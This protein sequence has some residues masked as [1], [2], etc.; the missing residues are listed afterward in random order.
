VLGVTAAPTVIAAAAQAITAATT[1]R[2]IRF[3]LR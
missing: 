2:C 1:A 3:S